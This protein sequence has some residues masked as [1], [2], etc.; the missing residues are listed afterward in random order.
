MSVTTLIV[1]GPTSSGKSRL[2][3]DIAQRWGAG[4]IN[5]DSQQVYQGLEILTAQPSLKMQ[6]DIPHTLYGYVNIMTSYSL[7]HWLRDAARAYQEIRRRGQ[8]VIVVGGTGFY[9]NSLLEGI[10]P[11]P[12]IDD[13]VRREIRELPKTFTSPQLHD[14]LRSEDPSMADR[15]HPSDSQRIL[16]AL[17]V[18]VGTGKSLLYWQSLPRTGPDFGTCATLVILPSSGKER[19]EL[20]DR[21]N[22]NV[23][24]RLEQGAIDEVAT[25]LKKTSCSL[26]MSKAIGALSIAEHIGGARSYDD[27]VT[28]IQAHTRQY[29][30]RQMTWMRHQM[31]PDVVMDTSYE[32]QDPAQLM[33][34]LELL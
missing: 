33:M 24:A 27:L 11:V 8:R 10:S 34:D 28:E 12:D 4:I 15:L 7:G 22:Q 9:M 26:T 17:E 1:A 2:A 13:E 20:Y 21:I 30:K 25:L 14:R 23:R 29:A 6:Q 32:G 16:R 3:V 5:A 19:K 18:I 31:V